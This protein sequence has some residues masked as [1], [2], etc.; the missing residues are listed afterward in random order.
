MLGVTSLDKNLSDIMYLSKTVDSLIIHRDSEKIFKLLKQL[1]E[2]GAEKVKG[3]QI[4]N[5]RSENKGDEKCIENEYQLTDLEVQSLRNETFHT[6]K[7]IEKTDVQDMVSGLNLKRKAKEDLLFKK[8]IHAE[9]KSF[10]FPPRLS[11]INE[12]FKI[13]CTNGPERIEVDFQ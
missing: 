8:N 2:K 6:L 3:K 1:A 10:W 13:L 12:F 5:R 9:H 4:T 7:N 11:E